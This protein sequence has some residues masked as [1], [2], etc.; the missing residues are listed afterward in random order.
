MMEESQVGLCTIC[1]CQTT[2]I[3]WHHTVPQALGGKDSL[4][5]PLCSDCHT[6]LHK[7]ALAVY[8]V[9]A[10]KSKKIDKTF[11]TDPEAERNAEQFVIIIVNAMLNPPDRTAKTYKMVVEVDTD[12]HEGLNLLK[13]DLKGMG[14]TN[15]SQAILHCIKQ[16]L[17]NKGLYHVTSKD[18]S[19]HSRTK[20]KNSLWSMQRVGK[21]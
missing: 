1:H 11:W 17:Q 19:S 6:T 20:S 5:I 10:G 9:V 15:L 8:S 16:T 18:S 4:Q 2:A 12:L 13:L 14:V 3:E 7:K 21:R